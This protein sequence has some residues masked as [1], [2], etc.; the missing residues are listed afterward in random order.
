MTVTALQWAASADHFS[1]ARLSTHQGCP[2]RHS[3][4]ISL[5]L[6]SLLWGDGHEEGE[7]V[8]ASWE[9]EREIQSQQGL[10]HEQGLQECRDGTALTYE[11]CAFDHL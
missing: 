7:M 3:Y 4:I 10:G 9:K 2:Q 8:I 6:V 5:S 1:K 11:S